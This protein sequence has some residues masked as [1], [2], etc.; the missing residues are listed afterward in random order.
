VGVAELQHQSE[1]KHISYE[2]ELL[3]ALQASIMASA[4]QPG[5]GAAV[6]SAVTASA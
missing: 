2:V 5:D 1:Q 6:A 3:K 4:P